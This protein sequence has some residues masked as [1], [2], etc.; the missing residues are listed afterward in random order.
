M[1]LILTLDKSCDFF[2]AQSNRFNYSFE[3]KLLRLYP[4]LDRS[5][6]IAFC[7]RGTF[8]LPHVTG[9][10]VQKPVKKLWFSPTPAPTGKEPGSGHSH[11]YEKKKVNKQKN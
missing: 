5:C 11:F 4:N 10:L 6:Q 9:F 2:A 8:C 3:A 1:V 7:N